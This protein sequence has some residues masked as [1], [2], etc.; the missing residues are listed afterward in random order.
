MF[1]RLPVLFRSAM[2]AL[3]GGFLIR[4]MAIAMVLGAAGAVLSSPEEAIPGISAWI[5]STLFP[6]HQD[7]GVAQV[8]LSSIATSIMTVVSIVFAILLMTLTLASTQFSPRILISF[9]RDRATQW[10]LGVLLGTFSYCIAVLPAAHSLPVAFA[11]VLSVTGAMLLALVAVAWLIFFI[12]H[13]SQSISVNHIVDRIARETEMVI[14]ELMPYPRGRF[15]PMIPPPLA[16][17]STPVL[18]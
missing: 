9:V 7:P 4:P 14:D 8:I 18:N 3:R 15:E 6:S 11:P 12:H 2:Y 5:P 17:D 1:E 10:T 16:A 13:I